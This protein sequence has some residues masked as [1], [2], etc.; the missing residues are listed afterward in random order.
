[1]DIFSKFKELELRDFDVTWKSPSNI[2]FVKYWGKKGH[3]LPANP[4]LS[5]TLMECNTTTQVQFKVSDKSNVVLFLDGV[6]NQTFAD[7]ISKFINTL[8]P[9]LPWLRYVSLTIQTSNNFPHGTG[10]A[11]SASGMSALCLCL[12]DYLYYLADLEEDPNFY[13]TASFLSRLGSGSACRSVFGDYSIW[14]ES[15]ASGSS[16]EFAIPFAPHTSFQGLQDSI[17]VIS[18]TE[19]KVSS[20]QGHGLMQGHYFAESRFRQASK[21]FNDLYHSMLEG[22]FDTFGRI[23]ELEALSLHAMMM[24]SPEPYMLIRPNTLLAMELI[25]DFRNQT[26]LPVFYT[27]D[28]GPNLHIIYPENIKE[29]IQTFI[30]H[31]LEKI[32]EKVIHD[33]QGEGPIRC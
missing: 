23:L 27:L 9:Q 26:G 18:S 33:Q 7:K 3:Q 21:N 32:S 31:E 5:M 2:A 30:H 28:A 8:F 16:D 6:L 20:R 15:L 10:I 17:L 11:S 1:M 24:T 13:K 25:A 22:D 4:S 29:K 14:G 12:T 19:K